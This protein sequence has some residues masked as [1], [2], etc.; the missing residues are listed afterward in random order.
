MD[1]HI[2]VEVCSRRVKFLTVIPAFVEEEMSSG[3]G[4]G[5]GK[6]HQFGQEGKRSRRDQVERFT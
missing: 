1:Y 3:S 6:F 4:K 5:Q 2:E